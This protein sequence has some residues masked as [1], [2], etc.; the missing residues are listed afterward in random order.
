VSVLD[1]ELTGKRAVV[2]GGNRGIR[3]AAARALVA[4]GC[5]V[6]LVAR[7]KEALDAAREAL[8]AAA[9]GRT[10]AR[11]GPRRD[12]PRP[13]ASVPLIDSFR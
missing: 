13:R 12:R 4:E 11:R 10:G 5:E 2:T 6:A 1:L 8:L 7:D 3:L 9:P